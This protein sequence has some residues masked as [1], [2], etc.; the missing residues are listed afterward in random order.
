MSDKERSLS[1]YYYCCCYFLLQKSKKKLVPESSNCDEMDVLKDHSHT[2]TAESPGEN[3]S[4]LNTTPN[5]ESNVNI[6]DGDTPRHGSETVRTTNDHETRYQSVPGG[7]QSVS[8]KD[9]SEEINQKIRNRANDLE[10]EANTNLKRL[11]S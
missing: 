1:S 11:N 10:T 2:V 7:Y 4:L 6:N 5:V 3:Q 8:G 9:I